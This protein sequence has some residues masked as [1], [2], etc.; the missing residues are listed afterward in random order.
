MREIVLNN[1]I[2]GVG[3]FVVLTMVALALVVM[4]YIITKLAG[5]CAKGLNNIVRF[6]TARYWVQRMESEGLTIMQKDYRRMVQERKPKSPAD[7]MK[8][9]HEF[10]LDQ[11]TDYKRREAAPDAD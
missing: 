7:Y 2:W 5:R 10:G 4:L 3:A 6:Q 9:G 1:I 11:E 8:L